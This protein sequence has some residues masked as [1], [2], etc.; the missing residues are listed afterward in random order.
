MGQNGSARAVPV[1][2]LAKMHTVGDSQAGYLTTMFEVQQFV[3][4]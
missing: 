2:T 4:N 1:H 3:L